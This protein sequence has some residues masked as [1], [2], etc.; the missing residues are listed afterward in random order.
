MVTKSADGGMSWS[1]P[2]VVPGSDTVDPLADHPSLTADP[3][4]AKVAYAIWD[5]SPSPHSGAGV[6]TR[7][8]D[9]GLTW[10]TARAI[11]KEWI[12]GKPRKGE[13]S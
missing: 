9:G 11:G 4:N 3:T 6:F 5:G 12:R 13:L 1:V 8:T 10:E 2:S 7:T